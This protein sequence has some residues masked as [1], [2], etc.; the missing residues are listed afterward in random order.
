M[1]VPVTLTFLL[2]FLRIFMLS[3]AAG[4]AIITDVRILELDAADTA[5]GDQPLDSPYRQRFPFFVLNCSNQNVLRL[6]GIGIF[7]WND[8]Q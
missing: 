7:N 3:S 2:W 8:L 1:A 6:H 4:N 5:F